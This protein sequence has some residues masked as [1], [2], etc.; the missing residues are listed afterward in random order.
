[1]TWE[2]LKEKAKELGAKTNRE[3]NILIAGLI[4]HET[5]DIECYKNVG[6]SNRTYEQMYQIMLALKK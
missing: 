2:Q 1:M 5:G 6:W 3:N 4:F